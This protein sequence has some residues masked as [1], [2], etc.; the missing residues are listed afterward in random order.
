MSEDSPPI[1]K[2]QFDRDQDPLN[3]ITTLN[4]KSALSGIGDGGDNNENKKEMNI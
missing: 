3:C 1:G 4:F 2:D